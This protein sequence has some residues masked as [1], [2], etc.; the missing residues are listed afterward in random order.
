MQFAATSTVGSSTNGPQ[1]LGTLYTRAEHSAVTSAGR[2]VL[3]TRAPA[4]SAGWIDL[5]AWRFFRQLV[6]MALY[7]KERSRIDAS[8]RVLFFSSLRPERI[9]GEWAAIAQGGVA[10]ALDPR[11]S[12]ERI[13]GA[14][15][16]LSPRVA[17]AEGDA[18][19]ERLLRVA[20]TS[21]EV[22]TIDGTSPP[23]GAH[24]PWSAA[25]ELGGTLDTAERAQAFRAAARALRPE[26][27]AIA[28]P[29]T[30]DGTDGP[31]TLSS[32][33][34]MVDRL[35]ELWADVPPRPD[36][37]A[38]VIDPR[39][40]A[41]MP[42]ALWAFLADGQTTIAIGSPDREA[43]EVADLRPTWVVGPREALER[44]ARA[45]SLIA[46]RAPSERLAWIDWLRRARSG[47]T[48]ASP[49]RASTPSVPQFL[50]P[51]G[52]RVRP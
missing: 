21:L 13:A 42:V 12:D 35:I 19:R 30:G 17:F 27:P 51:E 33:A 45:Q 14:L 32:H 26:A 50:S 3:R 16:F 49:S 15:K 43:E 36:G 37:T 22:I 25:M 8:D 40:L 5:P 38:Y 44:A 10:A 9:V 28:H 48:K 29:R 24:V 31:W 4:G 47:V 39:T 6:R 20:K 46:E 7:L 41:G 11:S 23:E 52:Q 1:T 34:A 18:A 2:T